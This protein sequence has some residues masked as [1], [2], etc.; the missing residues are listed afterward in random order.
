[1]PAAALS[2][3]QYLGAALDSST[4]GAFDNL[5]SILRKRGQF[6][7]AVATYRQSIEVLRHHTPFIPTDHMAR[8]LGGT[9]ERLLSDRR[10]S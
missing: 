10:S 8:I 3:S 4:S 1:M 5:A 9:L 7:E 2:E 6:D